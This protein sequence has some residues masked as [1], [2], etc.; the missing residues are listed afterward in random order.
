MLY[1]ILL[2]IIRTI[3]QNVDASTFGK[4][5]VN[6]LSFSFEATM[7]IIVEWPLFWAYSFVF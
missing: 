6:T 3:G 1:G 7:G 5:S 4:V 2:E